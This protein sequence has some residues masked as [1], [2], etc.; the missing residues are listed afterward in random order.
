M[1]RLPEPHRL[2]WVPWITV[3][4][5][6]CSRDTVE[7]PEPVDTRPPVATTPSHD[8][9]QFRGDPG[10]TGIARGSL[11]DRPE[12]LWTYKTDSPVLSS[13]VVADGRVFFGSDDGNVHACRVG[14]G[15]ALWRYDTGETVEA[16]PLVL[17]NRVFVGDTGGTLHALDAAGGT[18]LWK[19]VTGDKIIGAANWFAHAGHTNLLVGSHDFLLYSLDADTGTSNWV[20]ETGNYINGTPA[21][22]G[23]ITVFGGCDA[24]LH[25]ISAT[26]GTEL[27]QVDAGAYVA[28]S[29]ALLDGRAYY[30]HYEN[31]YLCVDLA[32]GTNV[33]SYRQRNFPYF[34]SPAVTSERVPFGGRDKR[35]HCVRRDTGEEL[36]TF[37]TRGKVD[38]SPVV[39]GDKVVVGSAD[40]RLYMVALA[41]GSELWSY[42]IGRPLTAS[43]AVAR[44][45]IIIGSEDGNVYCFGQPA[46]RHE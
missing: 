16:P 13:A 6:G 35:L 23:G 21:V 43:P 25:V 44:G 5:M 32:G 24:I 36:W 40:G 41:D 46:P 37:A 9:P 2:L 10:L 27:K 8:W 31:E 39:C 14:D 22:S 33:W 17:G 45:R 4:L 42:E 11:P 1:M 15:A 20:Y 34:S 7:P 3:A 29:A 18:P 12:L 26:N 38:S 19:F 30:G 28:G